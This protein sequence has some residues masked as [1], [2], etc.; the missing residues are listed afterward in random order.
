MALVT[1]V[2]REKRSRKNL[3]I[4]MNTN[5]FLVN[6]K[7]RKSECIFQEFS[8]GSVRNF[9]M[10]VETPLGPLLYLRVWH[11]NSGEKEK[12]SWFL[13]MINIMDL[14]TGEKYNTIKK[15]KCLS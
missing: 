2:C 6:T 4:N 7:K 11:D 5:Y 13:N 14:Q 10:S 1:K 9:V 3:I 8:S 12:A 15:L